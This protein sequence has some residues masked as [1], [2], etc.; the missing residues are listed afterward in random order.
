MRCSSVSTSARRTCAVPVAPTPLRSAVVL[1][2][3][4]C[5]D[6]ARGDQGERIAAQLVDD[7][8]D[9]DSAAA[10]IVAFAERAD[11]VEQARLRRLRRHVDGGID[12]QREDAGSGHGG[13]AFVMSVS[14]RAGADE[15]MLPMTRLQEY[16]RLG[17]V[18]DGAAG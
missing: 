14:V 7:A 6:A 5:G 11:L 9:V 2:P 10:R 13:R 17:S 16:R 18:A 1:S 15:A 4:A 12:G 8:R 3:L